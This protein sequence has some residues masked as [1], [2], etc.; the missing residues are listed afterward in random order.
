MKFSPRPEQACSTFVLVACALSLSVQSAQAQS[1]KSKESEDVDALDPIVVTGSTDNKDT[2]AQSEITSDLIDRTQSATIPG[3]LSSL[4]GIELIG[5]SRVLGQ[6]INMMAFGDTED[7]EITIDG[8]QK[9]FEKYQQ[10]SVFID[11]ELLKVIDITKGTFSAEKYGAFGGSVEMTTKSASDMLRDGQSYG[12]FAKVGF[13]SNGNELVKSAATFARSEEQGFEVLVAGTHRTNDDYSVAGNDEDLT[14]SAGSM[15]TGHFKANLEREDHFFEFSGMYSYSDDFKPWAARR[16]LIK[17]K[18]TSLS[19]YGSLDEYLKTQAVD[20]EMKDTSLSGTYEYNPDSDLID[21]A[22]KASYSKTAQHDTRRVPLANPDY[23]ADLYVGGD[24][25]TLDYSIY[26]LDLQ[27]T[28]AFNWGEFEN[29]LKYGVQMRHE[30]RDSMAFKKSYVGDP[31]YNNGYLQPYNIPSGTQTIWSAWGEYTIGYGGLELTPGLR[32]DYI[33]TKGEANLASKY[34]DPEINHDYGTVERFGFSPSI[35]AVYSLTPNIKLFGDYAYKLRAPLVDELYDVGSTRATATQLQNERVSAKRI[36]VASTYTNVLMQNDTITGRMSIYRNDVSNNIYRLL[37]DNKGSYDAPAP[38]YGNLA[39]YYTQGFEAELYYDSEQFFG[40]I[41]YSRMQGKHHGTL[42]NDN[43]TTDQYVSEV[44]PTKLIVSL[45]YK[46]P[47]ADITFG[48]KGRFVDAQDRVPD[49]Y[50]SLYSPSKGYAVHDVFLTWTPKEGRFE[51]LEARASIENM[52]NK[53]YRP[54]FA[55]G[56][57]PE[58][59]IN[60]KSS[61]SYKF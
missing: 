33:H 28:S 49:N 43:A 17:P 46:V 48:W 3:L 26:K 56:A 23:S 58:K 41:A 38:T 20:R 2:I 27:N 13:A 34:N 30:I 35:S 47:E 25:S 51:G 32:Y 37:S 21:L 22:F 59:G 57:A 7:I 19:K 61:V 44:A 4:P 9:S 45:G 39:G 42:K 15:L 14:L 6:S 5:N 50:T 40:S 8:A 36:G 55:D 54:Y 52:F 12:A 31:D 1:N 29:T 60:F 10:G 24:D 16:G 53:N 11:P 18:Q